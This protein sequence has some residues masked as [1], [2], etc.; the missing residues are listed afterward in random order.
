MNIKILLFFPS[1]SN[2]DADSSNP[3]VAMETEGSA[4]HTSSSLY[5]K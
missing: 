5:G 1:S 3:P 4:K 2:S